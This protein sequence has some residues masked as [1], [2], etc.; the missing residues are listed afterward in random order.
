MRPYLTGDISPAGGSFK[1]ALEDFEVEEVPAYD[2]TGQ[3][4]HVFL[5]VEKRGVAHR[6]M[7]RI[8]YQHL[9]ATDRDVSTAGMKDR[10]GITRQFVCVHR[11][12]EPALATFSH[13]QVKIL[14]A[15]RHG[16]KLKTGHLR[17]NRFVVVLRDVKDVSAA[18]AALKRITEVGLPNWFGMQRFGARGDN[19][20]VGKR[21]LLGEKLSLPH[22]KRRLMLSAF[23]SSLFNEV[24]ARRIAA[25][26]L[27]TAQSGD[28][29]KKH[30]SNGEFVCTSVAIDQPR[31]TSFEVSPTGPMFGPEMRAPE[32]APRELEQAVLAQAGLTPE[33]FK[34]GGRDTLGTRRFL[35][36]PVTEAVLEHAA[37][38]V[39]LRFALPAGSY[40][41]ELVRE[42]V[43]PG[44][45][46]D[47]LPDD[48]TTEE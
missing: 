1:V 33:A 7:I 46:A 37:P 31:V 21:I 28:V 11:K 8:L 4:E 22:F 27:A 40:A 47:A 15:R 35:R 12:F 38:H 45:N 13:P 39:R 9:G 42:L 6:D 43:K 16:N 41:S 24:L 2:P 34:L 36:V 48:E 30:G 29:L 19:A 32:G 25:G 20:E 10:F 14:S 17:G 3:G 18:E 44:A 23:Q 5:W 26:T